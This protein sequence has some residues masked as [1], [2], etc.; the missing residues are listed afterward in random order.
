MAFT[1]SAIPTVFGNK[2]TRLL[3][4]TADAAEANVASGFQ[5]IEWM[6]VGKPV[7]MSTA[8]PSVVF[9][10]NSTGTAAN[11]TIGVSGLSSG[12]ELY[13]LVFGK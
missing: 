4:I 10:K 6:V 13:C 3:T 8:N 7:S 11:G 9:N 5:V 12:A 2:S 1:V